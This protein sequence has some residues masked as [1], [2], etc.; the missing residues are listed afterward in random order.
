MYAIGT[1]KYGL[2]L[3][4]FLKNYDVNRENFGTH[5]LAQTMFQM[6]ATENVKSQH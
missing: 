3:T 2:T 4:N 5:T 1:N 6:S